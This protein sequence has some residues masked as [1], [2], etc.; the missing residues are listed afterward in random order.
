MLLSLTDKA[1][2]RLKPLIPTRARLQESIRGDLDGPALL[3]LSNIL[4]ALRDR[5][6][7]ETALVATGE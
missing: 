5:M 4:S 7:K 6:R 1:I 2:R 3:Q